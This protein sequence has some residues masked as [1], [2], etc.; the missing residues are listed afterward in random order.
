MKSLVKG[1]VVDVVFPCRKLRTSFF[2]LFFSS[3]SF[4]S[5]SCTIYQPVNFCHQ[6]RA[7]PFSCYFPL[8]LPYTAN[9]KILF[10]RILCAIYF[11]FL[12]L[13][14]STTVFRS[15]P[16]LAKTIL[17]FT[18]FFHEN[19]SSS[20]TSRKWIFSFHMPH[21]WSIFRKSILELSIHNTLLFFFEDV[22]SSFDFQAFC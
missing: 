22:G 3:I 13:I 17:L 18:Q 10:S 14:S 15:F 4:V 7:S 12:F 2:F 21:S 11:I 8:N 19:F 6:L 1:V 9:M 5:G 16:T 20:T